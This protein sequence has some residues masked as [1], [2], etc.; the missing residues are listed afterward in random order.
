MSSKKLQV[1]LVGMRFHSPPFN[2]ASEISRSTPILKR[3]PQNAHDKNAVAVWLSGHKVGYIDK[4]SAARVSQLIQTGVT[5]IIEVGTVSSQTIK[6]VLKYEVANLIV[7]SPKPNPRNASGIYKI[8]I[9][10]GRHVYIGQSNTINSRLKTHWNDLATQAHPNRHLQG[11]WNDLGESHFSAEIVELVPDHLSNG[12]EKQRWLAAREKFW[13]EKY[14]KTSNCLNI[15][16]G[17]VIPTKKALADLA[18]EEKAHDLKIKEEK[19]QITAELKI[20]EE[21]LK[22]AKNN[23][24]DLDSKVRELDSFVFKN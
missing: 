18:S 4:E 10:S 12:L 9:S 22:K 16:D 7:S 21:K 3:E 2:V 13:I 17:E 19:K 20:L 6:L 23:E 14:R 1:S 24:Q 8:S 5:F 11:H 15:L